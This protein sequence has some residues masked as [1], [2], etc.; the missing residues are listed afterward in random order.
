MMLFL[1]MKETKYWFKQINQEKNIF[2]IKK[3]KKFI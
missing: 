3:E 2:Q 1:M